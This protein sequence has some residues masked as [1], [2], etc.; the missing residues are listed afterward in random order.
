M[1]PTLTMMMMQPNCISWVGHCP[2]IQTQTYDNLQFYRHWPGKQKKDICLPEDLNNECAK[3]RLLL[4]HQQMAFHIK[5]SCWLNEFCLLGDLNN[6]YVEQSLSQCH[7]WMVFSRP[8]SS[9]SIIPTQWGLSN[10]RPEQWMCS[11][12]YIVLHTLCEKK[13]SHANIM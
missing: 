1:M 12:P 10:R 11:H 4:W 7:W 3:Q 6:Q 2:H 8:F 5:L 9:K 13:W